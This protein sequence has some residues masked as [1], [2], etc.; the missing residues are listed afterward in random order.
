MV[1]FQTIIEKQYAGF[2]Y[3][4]I[5]LF[6]E[7]STKDGFMVKPII[8]DGGY[9]VLFPP[10]LIRWKDDNRSGQFFYNVSKDSYFNEE[11]DELLSIEDTEYDI[12]GVP[13]DITNS[14]LWKIVSGM[15]RNYQLK[16]KK[17]LIDLLEGQVTP[18]SSKLVTDIL[19]N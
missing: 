11:G 14:S 19:F 7:H 18:N 12:K 10:R 2:C 8:L 16:K 5:K 15:K 3:V 6:K 13:E 1:S 4:Y 17:L 9:S